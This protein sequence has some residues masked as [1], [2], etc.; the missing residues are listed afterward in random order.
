[1]RAKRQ[2]VWVLAC[3]LTGMAGRGAAPER[4]R[5]P[6]SRE[7][8][9]EV[10]HSRSPYFPPFMDQGRVATCD[11]FA[12]A[13]YQ[14]TY[15]LNRM[16]DRPVAPAN[17]FSPKFGFTLTNN[18]NVYPDNLW[19]VDVYALLQRHGAPFLTDLPYDL[20]AGAHHKEWPRDLELWK[21]AMAHRLEGYE[22][23]LFEQDRVKDL[24]R[25]G[26]V[27]VIQFDYQGYTTS[28]IL[29]NPGDPKG[30]AH[31]GETILTG[32]RCG[33]DHTVALVGYN[34]H[35]W[36]DLNGDGKVQPEELGAFK[37]QESFVDPAVNGTYRWV[38][39]A[40][41]RDP[42][43]TIFYENKVWRIRMRKDYQP[44][45]VAEVV[46][47]HGHRDALKLQVGW[48]EQP[49]LE[50]VHQAK[51]AWVLDPSGMGF[52]PGASGKSLSAG[53]NCAFDG[54]PAPCDG[55]FAFDLTDLLPSL[56]KG[57]AWFLRLS[58]ASAEPVTLKA[59]RI[60]DQGKAL[61]PKVLPAPFQEKELV[62]FIPAK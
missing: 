30:K 47:N 20:A 45:V 33:P 22:F 17:T 11:W 37:L 36:T 27:L 55:G 21:K 32:G 19:F 34:D 25:S 61:E 16:L 1:M 13:Y 35:V 29:P 7:D 49:T 18:A 28:R 42:K 43:T 12:C 60:L 57:G 53:A 10:D 8:V 26:E 24:L 48:V 51:A 6:F 14:M 3:L 52:Q 62:V 5:A 44:K 31:A 4:P 50:A 46:L 38:A 58:N 59:F 41:V 39:Y 56:G 2:F 15:T 9:S 54:G 23:E 40:A